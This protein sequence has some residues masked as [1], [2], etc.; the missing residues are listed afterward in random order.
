M[1]CYVINR[2]PRAA[3][4]GKVA[5]EVWTGNEVDYSELRVFGCPAYV[6]VSSDQRTNLIRNQEN[7]FFRL[8]KRRKG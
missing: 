8:C 2:S 5:D 4:D 7:A 1:A 3:L 6:H